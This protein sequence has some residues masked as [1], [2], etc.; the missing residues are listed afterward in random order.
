MIVRHMRH[1][2]S[3][4]FKCSKKFSHLQ[5]YLIRR[6]NSTNKNQDVGIERIRNIGI[7]AHI[8]AGS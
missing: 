1:L 8:D 7:L 5:S 3:H 2:C 4:G 6:Y